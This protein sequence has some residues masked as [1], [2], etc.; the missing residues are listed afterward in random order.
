MGIELVE[1]GLKNVK[2]KFIA[3]KVFE[4]LPEN[5]VEEYHKIFPE[6]KKLKFPDQWD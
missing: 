5:D 2:G 1:N 6:L 4:N 3:S